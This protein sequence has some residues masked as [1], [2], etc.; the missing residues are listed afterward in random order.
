MSVQETRPRYGR[1]AISDG[2][3]TTYGGFS[4]CQFNIAMNN[5]DAPKSASE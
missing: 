3:N 5:V 2:F 4:S 1:R